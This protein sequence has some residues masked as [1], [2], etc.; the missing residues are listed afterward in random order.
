MTIREAAEILYDEYTGTTGRLGNSTQ[1]A[2]WIAFTE[3]VVRA[4]NEGA[5][6]EVQWGVRSEMGVRGVVSLAQ[7]EG[8]ARSVALMFG[9]T[10]VRRTVTRT[11]WEEA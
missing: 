6:T 9:A 4:A 7:D 3:K 10:P 11:P 1:E 2:R 5:E 8:A